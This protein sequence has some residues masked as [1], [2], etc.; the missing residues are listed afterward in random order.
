MNLTK[1]GL[2]NSNTFIEMGGSL[3]SKSSGTYTPSTG[4]NSCMN[5][6]AVDLSSVADLGVPIVITVEFDFTW[7]NFTGHSGNGTFDMWF[8]GSN[9]KKE[10][11]SF[12]WAG[13]NYTCLAL[14]RPA[15]LIK[16][17][18]TGG[19]YH[20]KVN[21]TI[22]VSWFNTYNGSNFGVRT[23]Y[24]NGTGSVTISNLSISY[25]A[26]EKNASIANKYIEANN[27]YEY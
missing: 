23:D 12:V 8:Q 25:G 7:T 19:S 4:T 17:A 27:F 10:D 20:Y 26:L 2:L 18:L 11:N 24:S 5:I 3:I 21:N 15:N 14:T 22:P 16:G 13:T 1:T 6:G 9:R